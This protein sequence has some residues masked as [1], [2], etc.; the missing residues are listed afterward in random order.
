MSEITTLSF[1]RFSGFRNKFWAL[2]MMQFAHQDLKETSGQKFY[3]LMGSGKGAGF[4]PYPDWETYAL[5]QVWE[6]EEAADSFFNNSSII[7]NYH[8]HTTEVWTLFLKSIRAKGT[9]SGKKP[10]SPG[11]DLDPE[12]PLLAVITRATLRTSRLIDFWKYV[13]AS[14]SRLQSNPGLIFTKGIGEIPVIQMATFSLWKDQEAM[15]AYAYS[16]KGHQGAIKKTRELDWYKEELFSRF[17]P[18][19]SVG[20]W[21]GEN[22]L[23]ELSK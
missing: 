3:K 20:T 23:P 22:P 11:E 5:L 7:K 2:K 9:W 8:D 19:R 14:Q 21:Q 4:N 18:Y 15:Y 17:Q 16:A 10:F 13:P 1:F 6:S 12:N